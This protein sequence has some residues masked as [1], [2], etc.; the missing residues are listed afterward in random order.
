[1]DKKF[2]AEQYNAA[3][4]LVDVNLTVRDLEAMLRQAA[5]QAEELERVRKQ[6]HVGWCR[7]QT[8]EGHRTSFKACDSDAQGA[9]KVYRFPT[10]IERSKS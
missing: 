4:D 10:A 3:A 2:N 7:Y 6:E 9:F 5:R 8:H 1:M